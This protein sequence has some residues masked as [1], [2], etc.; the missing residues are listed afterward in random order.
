MAR[1]LARLTVHNPNPTGVEIGVFAPPACGGRRSEQETTKTDGAR[2][3]ARLP[4]LGEE[5]AERGDVLVRGI[6]EE[7]VAAL[8]TEVYQLR[9]LVQTLLS[10]RFTGRS[11]E[12]PSPAAP[13]S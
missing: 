10:D 7:Q 13:T 4:D 5:C 1:E 8:R 6:L 2:G 12:P 11:E 3:A 9:C